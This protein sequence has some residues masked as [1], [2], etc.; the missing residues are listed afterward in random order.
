MAQARKPLT[1]R[2][3]ARLTERASLEQGDSGPAGFRFTPERHRLTPEQ[4]VQANQLLRKAERTRPIREQTKRALRIAGIVSAVKRG[5]VGNSRFGRSLHAHRGGRVMRLHGLHILRAIA[6]I[7]CLAAMVAR[8]CRQAAAY[9]DAIGEVLP[10]GTQPAPAH[11]V[12]AQHIQSLTLTWE[13]AQQP[14]Q[15]DRLSW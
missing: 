5:A 10:I 13:A 4:C 12:Q 3:R 2:D 7:G 1:P 9:F 11:D 8:E 14:A 15:R 6:P